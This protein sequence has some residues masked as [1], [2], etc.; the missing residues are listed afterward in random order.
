M[1]IT[2][3]STVLVT[4]PTASWSGVDLQGLIG[5]VTALE[6]YDLID[7]LLDGWDFPVSFSRD[8]LTVVE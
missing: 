8:E 4:R 1:E 2:V 3:G 6:A 7:V 5:T